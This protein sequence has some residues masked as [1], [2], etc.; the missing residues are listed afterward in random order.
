MRYDTEIEMWPIERVV[1]YDHN[2]KRHTD[3]QIE[4]LAKTIA[5]IGWDQP[6]VVDESNV[7]LKGH[8]RRLAA[9]KLGLKLVPVT[10][11][12]GLSEV[13][14]K[15]ARIS[16]NKLNEA[17]WIPEL[18]KMELEDIKLSGVDDLEPM[19]FEPH[20]L[21]EIFDEKISPLDDDPEKEDGLEKEEPIVFVRPGD[22]WLLGNHILICGDSTKQED[23]QKLG[24][25]KVDMIFT[26]PPYGVKYDA[27]WRKDHST[28]ETKN[29]G[30]LQN[31]HIADWTATFALVEAPVAYVWH[32]AIKSNITQKMLTDNEYE[33][34]NQIIW[35]K[36]IHAISRGD[37]HWKHE[38]AWY[39]V[40][41]GF[42]SK[43]G[44][45]RDQNT[46]WDCPPP[47]GYNSKEDHTGHPSQKPVALIQR[48]LDNHECETIYDPFLGS[49]ST[50]IA[51]QKTGKTCIGMEIDPKFAS[52][53]I[54]R[55][56][57]FVESSEKVFRDEG[58]FLTPYAK[59]IASQT[60]SPV[61]DSSSPE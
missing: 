32:S 13:L 31:D 28:A 55:Y 41:K 43:W 18:L 26:D 22:R 56:V 29:M 25:E 33:I 44:G 61:E 51:C 36:S 58:K 15:K 38:P 12:R 45:K 37:Y 6:I 49:G 3:V 57:K 59:V 17:S 46:V 8:G 9:L 5:E 54:Q 27:D 10:V 47:H 52:L 50:L 20:E 14:K 30:S 39:A 11:K 19:G 24:I 2:P 35:N 7:I 34:R 53:I 23:V 16:D 4:K 60:T 48:A 21:K 1:P 42:K 40:R